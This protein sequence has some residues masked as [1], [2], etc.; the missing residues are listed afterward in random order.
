MF[1]KAS[2]TSE[3]QMSCSYYNVF[4][5]EAGTWVEGLLGAPLGPEMCPDPG[6][7]K[8]TDGGH[9]IPPYPIGSCWPVI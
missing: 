4:S 2:G 1:E 8:P 3:T 7:K 6:S 5:L 9:K